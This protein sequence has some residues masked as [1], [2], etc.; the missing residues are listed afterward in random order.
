MGHAGSVL[1]ELHSHMR[2]LG[3][4]QPPSPSPDP[5]PV[6]ALDLETLM[7]TL[8]P[9][10]LQHFNATHVRPLL[11]RLILRRARGV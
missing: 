1:S 10:V 11:S 8:D 6:P 5:T 3:V 4:Q 2:S 9:T 7:N